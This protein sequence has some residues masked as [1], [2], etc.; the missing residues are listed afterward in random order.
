M[1]AEERYNHNPIPIESE[2]ITD[3]E[4]RLV[5]WETDEIEAK[6]IEGTYDIYVIAYIE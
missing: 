3:L 2:S 4:L 6:D 5:V 1:D